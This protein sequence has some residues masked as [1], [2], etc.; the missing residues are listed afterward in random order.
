MRHV[1]NLHFKQIIFYSIIL[2]SLN[3]GII[4]DFYIV[5]TL[6]WKALCFAVK[7]FDKSTAFSG[8]ILYIKIAK[9]LLQILNSIHFSCT[10]IQVY[11]KFC[12]CCVCMCIRILFFNSIN[13]IPVSFKLYI[14]GCKKAKSQKIFIICI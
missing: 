9:K 14:L 7:V 5:K 3:S 6:L 8:R 10:F 2:L 13:Y 11:T 4:L 12:I 1:K